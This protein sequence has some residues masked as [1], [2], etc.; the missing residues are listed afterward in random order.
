MPGRVD[1]IAQ[2]FRNIVVKHPA[3]R[4]DQTKALLSLLDRCRKLRRVGCKRA[5]NNLAFVARTGN[6]AREVSPPHSA[7]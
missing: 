6:P 5:Q 4:L 1:R 7:P 3:V 2:P